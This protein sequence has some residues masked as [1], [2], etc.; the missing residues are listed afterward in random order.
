M[1]FVAAATPDIRF[2]PSPLPTSSSNTSADRKPLAFLIGRSHAP[3]LVRDR[4]SEVTRLAISLNIAGGVVNASP[5]G[6]NTERLPYAMR[7][8]RPPRL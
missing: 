5:S 7:P 2:S 1:L 8:E 4:E 6:V 3:W